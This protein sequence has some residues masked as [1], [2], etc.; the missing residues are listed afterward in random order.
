MC[1]KT[2]SAN[3]ILIAHLTFSE[4]LDCALKLIFMT[5]FSIKQISAMVLPER[6]VTEFAAIFMLRYDISPQMLRGYILLERFRGCT[7][8]SKSRY[9]KVAQLYIFQDSIN[10]DCLKEL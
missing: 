4:R 8:L 6:Y 3:L 9:T 2:N 10:V 5:N 7:D 1:T